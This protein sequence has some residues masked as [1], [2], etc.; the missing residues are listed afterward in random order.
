MIIETEN[1]HEKREKDYE[2]KQKVLLAQLASEKGGMLIGGAI[3]AGI[4]RKQQ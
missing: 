2:E 4:H 1:I 3:G